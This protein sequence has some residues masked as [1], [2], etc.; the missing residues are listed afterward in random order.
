ML[1][2]VGGKE[3][4]KGI[5]VQSGVIFQRGTDQKAYGTPSRL[6]GREENRVFMPADGKFLPEQGK[7]GTGSAPIT[8]F[9]YG[10][11]AENFHGFTIKYLK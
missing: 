9:K 11:I 2:A 5:W 10:K 1:T 8:P 7:L 3:P 6:R 4:G